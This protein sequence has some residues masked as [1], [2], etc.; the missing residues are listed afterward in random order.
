MSPVT[1]WAEILFLLLLL[2]Q[3]TA[4]ETAATVPITG[5]PIT[6]NRNSAVS[7]E[8]PCDVPS[9]LALHANESGSTGASGTQVE[10]A[11]VV[12]EPRSGG[13]GRSVDTSEASQVMCHASWTRRPCGKGFG[14]ASVLVVCAPGSVVVEK[15]VMVIGCKHAFAAVSATGMPKRYERVNPL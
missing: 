11:M 5:M 6:R 7:D 2:Q 4:P 8:L 13:R 12:H 1:L 14:I 15:G 3:N 9:L 10:S